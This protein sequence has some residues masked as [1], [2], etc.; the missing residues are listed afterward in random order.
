MQTKKIWIIRT[1][2]LGDFILT[3][4]VIQNL[5]HHFPSAQIHLLGNLKTLTLASEE[6]D[7][8]HDINSTVWAPLFALES[9]LSPQLIEKSANTDLVIS[10]L[11]D[12][13][14]LFTRN[15]KRAGV[16]KVITHPPKPPED[17]S[18]HTIDHLLQPLQN[19]DIPSHTTQPAIHFTQA[20]FEMAHLPT[21]PTL[22]VHPGSGGAP[23]RWPAEH[24]I[25]LINNISKHHSI[26]VSA[27]PAD[28]ELAQ[29]IVAQ[30]Q[31]NLLSQLPIRRFA[32]LMTKCSAYL[33]NDSGPS[34]LAAAVGLPTLALFGP[35]D[36]HIWSPRSATVHTLQAS[37]GQMPSISPDQV[38]SKLLEIMPVTS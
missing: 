8:I 25:T 38:I 35:T 18:I 11:P 22:L 24:F 28:G 1:G 6:V 15:L 16:Q 29:H 21:K 14:G 17:G 37:D 20:D 10:Y 4:P 5:R 31:A 2:A 12:T 13:D 34:H 36:P 32:A 19:L 30:T 33:G 26:L 23:K 9:D 3:L 27:G 7:H